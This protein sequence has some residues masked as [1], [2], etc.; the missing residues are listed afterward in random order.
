MQR[1]NVATGLSNERLA[2]LTNWAEGMVDA[3]LIPGDRAAHQLNTHPTP[4]EQAT[5]STHTMHTHK[6]R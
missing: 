1:Q 3:G 2:R 5:Q 6:G 4:S